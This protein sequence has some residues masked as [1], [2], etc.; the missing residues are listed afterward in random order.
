MGWGGAYTWQEA[1]SG[2]VGG[3][4]ALQGVELG[5]Q[6]GRQI[7]YLDFHLGLLSFPVL[8]PFHCLQAPWL[9]FWGSEMSMLPNCAQHE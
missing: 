5:W 8:V 1:F 2:G 3:P 6:C 9:Q 7:P 4:D